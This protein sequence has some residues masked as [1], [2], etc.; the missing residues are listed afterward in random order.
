M[1]EEILS[2]EDQYRSERVCILP[3]ES[4]W[5]YIW[6]GIAFAALIALSL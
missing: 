6:V 4:H 5:S 2:D 3:E 1:R